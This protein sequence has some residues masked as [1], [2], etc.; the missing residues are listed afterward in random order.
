MYIENKNNYIY[1]DFTENQNQ[2][3]S[4]EF[5]YIKKEKNRN[6][7]FLND[8]SLVNVPNAVN[9]I[10]VDLDIISSLFHFVDYGIHF[11]YKKS[12]LHKDLKNNRN[13]KFRKIILKKDIDRFSEL[14]FFD[15]FQLYNS[16]FI[17]DK[18]LKV[19]KMPFILKF[20][21]LLPINY[22]EINYILYYFFYSKDFVYSLF[23]LKRL[24]RFNNQVLDIKDYKVYVNN[25]RVFIE[26]FIHNNILPNEVLENSSNFNNF[27]LHCYVEKPNYFTFIFKENIEENIFDENLI[28][29]E[30]F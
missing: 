12:L 18:N 23:E 11:I 9:Q 8:P 21:K 10:L 4:M 20:H 5:N 19:S 13:S 17:E 3:C 26:N 1:F 7:I 28:D 29:D 2:I 6:F 16:S 24:M 25:N 14:T 22:L 27:Y 15:N 30:S